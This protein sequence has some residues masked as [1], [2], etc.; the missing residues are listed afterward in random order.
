MN[1]PMKLRKTF[2][3]AKNIC[4]K[5]IE[6]IA[7]ILLPKSKVIKKIEVMDIESLFQK[8]PRS[9]I[10]D[11]N[12]IKAM[13]TYK[14]SF[15]RQAIWEIKFRANPKIISSFSRLFYEFLVEELS[16]LETFSNFKNPILVPIPSSKARLKEKGFNQCIL[17]A[18]ELEK[19]AEESNDKCFTVVTNLLL[20]NKDTPH[21]VS[22]KNRNKRLNNLHDSFS[23][24]KYEAKK[25]N[26]HG[27]P[28]II[29]DDVITTGATM[30]EAFRTF[31]TA[32][33]KKI[34]GF[35]LAH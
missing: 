10:I 35:A 27:R 24:N 6:W 12:K 13:F 32:G 3:W 28:V 25:H 31:K 7:D 11:N 18:K 33:V 23:I 20:K 5:F 16:E 8:I 34:I 29:I 1:I 22:I 14:N 15:C 21:Q 17:I 26:L 4:Y 19:I 9:D 30:N 2:T